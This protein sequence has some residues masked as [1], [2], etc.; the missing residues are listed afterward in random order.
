MR[1]TWK[2]G[3]ATALTGAAAALYLLWVGGTTVMG[4]SGSRAVSLAVFGLGIGG[5]Y[6]AKSNMEAVYAASG[7]DRPP[8]PYVV[9][10]SALGGVTLV[11]GIVA[12]SS[13]STAA[14]ATLTATIV[15]LWAMATIRHWALHP[16]PEATHSTC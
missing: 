6:T 16:T 3:L 4:L 2:D 7:R 8:I 14:L 9:G 5:C 12:I 1:L 15:A 10:A 13:G 11:A